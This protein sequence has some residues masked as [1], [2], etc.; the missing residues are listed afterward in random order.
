MT[1]WFGR[2]E[3]P[4]ECPTNGNIADFMPESKGWGMSHPHLSYFLLQPGVEWV[5]FDHWG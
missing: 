3:G 1:G 5:P 4:I 2:F